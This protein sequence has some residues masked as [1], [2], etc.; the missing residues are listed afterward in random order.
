MALVP[1]L[2]GRTGASRFRR[3]SRPRSEMPIQEDL[4][5]WVW[6][7]NPEPVAN[8][9]V[10]ARK[11][12]ALP[13]KPSKAVI[14]ACADTRYKLFVNGRYVGKGPVRAGEGYCYFDT[15]DVAELLNKGDNV[16]AVLAHHIG[17]G[18]Y[19]AVP[20]RPGL[21]CKIEIEV[22]GET[23]YLGTDESWKVHRADEWVGTGA[24]MSHRLGFQEIYDADSAPDGWTEAKFNEK[25]WEDAAKVGVVPELPWG[26]LQPREIPQLREETILP[27]AI[28]ALANTA[29]VGRETPAA[30]M[31]DIMALTEL[32]A[33]KTGSVKDEQML[34]AIDGVTHIKTPRGDK[35]V[36]IIIDFGR[37]VFGNVEV[38]IGGSGGGCIDLGYSEVLLEG[39]VKPNLGD[40]RY[41]DRIMLK[42][43]ALAWQSFE[44]RAFRFLQIEFRRCAKPVALQYVRVNQTTYPVEV[45][46]RFECD[47]RLLNEIWAAGV[48]TTQLCMEDTFIDCPWRERAQWWSDARILSRTAFYAFDDTALLA[49]GLRQI[50]SSQDKDGAVLGLYPA[51]VEMLAPDLA[52][53]WVYS[54][55]DYYAFSDDPE[56]V[57]ELYPA[58]QRLMKWF[59]RFVNPDGLLTGMPGNLQVDRA[60][61]ERKGEVTSLNCF[62]HQGLRV[63]S[64]LASICEKPEEAQEYI[65]AAHRLKVAINKFMYV[66]KRG[67]YAECRADG[68]LIE[69]FSRQTNILAALFDVT[70][71]YQKGSILRQL[72]GKTLAEITTPYFASYYLDALYLLERHDEALAYM[73]RKWGEMIKAGATTLWEDFISEGSL[74]HGSA[75]CPTRDLLAE[76]VGIKPVVGAH[77]FA[78]TPHTGD[79]KWA[80]GSVAT[81]AGPLT[82]EWKVLRNRLDIFVEVP[83]GLR[84]DV[85]PPGPVGSTITVDGRHWPTPFASL[86]GGSHVIRLTPPK[87]PRA[88]AYDELPG[89]CLIPHVEVLD[90]GVRIGR[91][92]VE[93]EPRGRRPRRGSRTD[94]PLE[95]RMDAATVAEP[96]MIDLLPEEHAAPATQA[97]EASE[98]GRGGKRR[99]RTRGGRGRKPAG[100]EPV[101][102]EPMHDEAPAPVEPVEPVA[103]PEASQPEPGEQ[104]SVKKR[105]RRSRGGRGRGR[106]SMTPESAASEESQQPLEE[107][108]AVAEIAQPAQETSEEATPAKRRR[109]SRGGRG[110]NRSSAHTDA[111]VTAPEE[112]SQPVEEPQMAEIAQP[113]PEAS[114]EAPAAKHRRRSR[115]GRGR[116]GSSAGEPA[117]T[118][119]SETPGEQPVIPAPEPEPA[120]AVQGESSEE[121]P[122]KRRRTYTRR[123]SPRSDSDQPAEGAPEPPQGEG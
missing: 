54:I 115:G 113:E 56:L 52:L 13:G 120:Q 48:Y 32:S 84:V 85:Y 70:D 78:V 43:G 15:F 30:S 101:S 82:V 39:H 98:D 35:G 83:E 27:R 9:Y 38:G 28:V 86:G 60:D 50:A 33:L 76:F 68:K 63:A 74:C 123:K 2:T 92:G 96:P 93:I 112:S 49:Q 100:A 69:K 1:A 62:Y 3:G 31:P 23:Q 18:T 71:Q 12:F 104:G 105:R 59:S 102:T 57:H 66:P 122:K 42:R 19:G 119:A 14:K 97:A 65:E 47:D 4:G 29:E 8:S 116:G 111:N 90:R 5:K 114:G 53:L 87:P 95:V 108:A 36:A 61:L 75:V 103:A 67:L 80:R 20:G 91:H 46:G 109:R 6:I 51:G 24:R 94:E 58:V 37:E 79:L 55:L 72:S 89:L 16:V 81:N 25:G 118:E 110:R 117:V 64:V 44:P 40:T 45:T 22:D 17:E 26:S 41:T 11:S 77:R 106:A 88:A 73:R 107:Q 121:Q 21:I 99:R 34:L 10:R 7:A